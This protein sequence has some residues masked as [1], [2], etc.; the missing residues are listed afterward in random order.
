[1][2]NPGAVMPFEKMS[3]QSL[4]LLVTRKHFLGIFASELENITRK[5]RRNVSSVLHT[6][7]IVIHLVCFNHTTV[8]IP[9]I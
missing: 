9:L 2:S 8:C 7:Y 6:Y 3:F 5:S 4:L 1:M